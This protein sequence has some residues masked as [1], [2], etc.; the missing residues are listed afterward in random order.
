V[1][2]FASSKL[3]LSNPRVSNKNHGRNISVCLSIPVFCLPDH[4]ELLGVG[5]VPRRSQDQRIRVPR[6]QEHRLNSKNSYYKPQGKK[7]GRRGE[8]GWR[9]CNSMQADKGRR[10]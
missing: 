5:G 3:H 4:G 10:E 9:L 2:H 6:V 7:D 8:K 1:T